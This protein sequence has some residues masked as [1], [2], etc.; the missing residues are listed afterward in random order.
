MHVITMEVDLPNTLKRVAE[1]LIDVSDIHVNVSSETVTLTFSVLDEHDDDPDPDGAA[2]SGDGDPSVSSGESAPDGLVEESSGSS[3]NSTSSGE[4][5]HEA[6]F[7]E[8]DVWWGLDALMDETGLQRFEVRR[9]VQRMVQF[10][11]VQRRN[12]MYRCAPTVEAVADPDDQTAKVLHSLDGQKRT[13]S[14]IAQATGIH[15]DEVHRII[16]ALHETDRIARVND[17]WTVIHKQEGVA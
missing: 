6:M 3:T 14:S 1:L 11:T 15:M 2:K 17:G 16:R 13:I 12:G 9:E 10:G 8:P 7:A 5:L 4:L